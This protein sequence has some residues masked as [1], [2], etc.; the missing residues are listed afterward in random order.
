MKNFKDEK[1]FLQWFIGFAEG[2]GLWQVQ[3]TPR[4]KR[5]TF[6]INQEDPQLLYKIKKLLKFG[7]VKGPY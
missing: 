5:C 4:T 6:A 3:N 1:H 7:T 2:E